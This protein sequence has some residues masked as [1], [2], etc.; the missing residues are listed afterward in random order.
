M[1]NS[2]R[3]PNNPWGKPPPGPAPIGGGAGG[4]PRIPV[5]ATPSG[6]VASPSGAI[7]SGGRPGAAASGLSP[8]AAAAPT[9][10]VPSASTP[11]LSPTG[12]P[13]MSAAP[14]PLV[15]V[16]QHAMPAIATPSP[17]AAAAS[18]S[19]AA[20]ARD[21]L[22]FVAHGN[23]DPDVAARG[24]PLGF[25]SLEEARSLTRPYA[26]LAPGAAAYVRGSAV[27]R[28]S[29]NPKKR[30]KEFGA[31]SDIDFG[32]ASS[33]LRAGSGFESH[34]PRSFPK[35]G[36][37]ASKLERSTSAAAQRAVHHK[38]GLAVTDDL[39]DV[40]SYMV[41]PPTPPRQRPGSGAAPPP[42]ALSPP[43]ASFGASASGSGSGGVG[44]SGGSS[45][46]VIASPSPM[47]PI[48]APSGIQSPP[49]PAA[50]SLSA[51]ATPSAA[52]PPPVHHAPPV[53]AAATP[54]PSFLEIARRAAASGGATGASKPAARPTGGGKP[55]GKPAGGG[56]GKTGGF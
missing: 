14:P 12:P 55:G 40:G 19:G 49:R 9:P 53:G 17:S 26:H 47:R 32:L 44:G 3:D 6:V 21:P 18:A 10:L 31:S 7:P 48:V 34:G 37:A 20:P 51:S 22:A 5:A 15:P 52:T 54:P 56:A 24:Y 41:R 50:P 33:S 38:M 1:S 36:S 11:G 43:V 25:N 42:L 13:S 27:T 28:M 2:K 29:E 46:P 4:P 8:M 39:P 23:V 30:G 16:Q 45:P 35:G